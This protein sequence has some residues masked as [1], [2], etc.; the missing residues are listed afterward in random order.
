MCQMRRV[1]LDS[2]LVTSLPRTCSLHHLQET[3]DYHFSLKNLT[4]VFFGFSKRKYFD[5][6]EKILAG[7][8]NKYFKYLID[9]RHFYTRF[10]LKIV[11]FNFLNYFNG[12]L[13]FRQP[14]IYI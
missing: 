3:R 10:Y 4:D 9:R 7:M 13:Y 1:K 6:C 11:R 8:I 12:K 14:M 2:I 5:W